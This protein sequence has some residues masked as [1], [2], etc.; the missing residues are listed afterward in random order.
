MRCRFAPAVLILCFG[1]SLL[2]AQVS[3]PRG[4]PKKK[5]DVNVE[6]AAMATPEV[7][8]VNTD[9]FPVG[10]SKAVI[11]KLKNFDAARIS[12]VKANLPCTATGFQ[13][14]SPTE[15]KFTV[16]VPKDATGSGCYGQ[17]VDARQ[18]GVLSW[19]VPYLSAE[20]QKEEARRQQENAR[21][22]QMQKEAHAPYEQQIAKAKQM[23]GNQWNL[24]FEGGKK[25]TLK[26]SKVDG[27]TGTFKNSSGKEVKVMYMYG[28]IMIQ[29]TAQCILQGPLSGKSVSGGIAMGQDCPGGKTM[30][31][32]NGTVQ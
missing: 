30:G 9:R 13:V 7:T 4:A 26:L 27:M 32:W 25:D 5:A 17:F 29:Y 16:S 1:S 28:N 21:V 2:C 24:E 12:G 31:K 18:N 19:I 6:R 14:S 15:V 11:M 20:A 3:V 23:L 22:E 8:L 10:T